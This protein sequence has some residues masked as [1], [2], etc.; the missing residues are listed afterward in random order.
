MLS[1]TTEIGVLFASIVNMHLHFA[2][3]IVSDIDVRPLEEL[4]TTNIYVGSGT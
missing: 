2:D 3:F 1:R 4:R